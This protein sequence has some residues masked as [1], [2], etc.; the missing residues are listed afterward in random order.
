MRVVRLGSSDRRLSRTT[1]QVSHHEQRTQPPERGPHHHR[2]TRR[3][4]RFRTRR[5]IAR[6]V[7]GLPGWAARTARCPRRTCGDRGGHARVDGS[8]RL[9]RIVPAAHAAAAHW[10]HGPTSDQRLAPSAGIRRTSRWQAVG[11]TAGHRLS[12]CHARPGHTVPGP[13]SPPPSARPSPR[14][15]VPGPLHTPRGHGGHLRPSAPRDVLPIGGV[16]GRRHVQGVV[17]R[18][19]VWARPPHREGGEGRTHQ[20]RLA[21]TPAHAPDPPEPLWPTVPSRHALGPSARPPTTTPDRVAGA[22]T[23]TPREEQES[24]LTEIWEPET[25]SRW[26]LCRSTEHAPR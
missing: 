15:P 3:R 4:V 23:T 17:D 19:Y 12:R 5:H 26:C 6:A 9:D 22:S 14:A 21:P 11:P 7:A 25:R 8:H 1:E 18:R 20:D 13:E 10:E 24:L 2:Q 16:C